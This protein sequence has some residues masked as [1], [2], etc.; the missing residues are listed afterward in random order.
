MKEQAHRG[1][2]NETPSRRIFSV[3]SLLTAHHFTYHPGLE[4]YE[5]QYPFAQIFLAV[6]GSGFYETDG[7]IYP[8]AAG[9]MVCRPANKRS[10]IRWNP[11][12]LHFLLLSF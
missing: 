6:E 4:P 7:Q 5:E 1:G 10:V 3:T 11:G 12:K 2:F 9:Q 8:I